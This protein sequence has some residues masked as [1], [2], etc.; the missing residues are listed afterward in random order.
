MTE[1]EE[2]MLVLEINREV[3]HHRML[4]QQFVKSQNKLERLYRKLDAKPSSQRS[5]P[6]KLPTS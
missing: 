6:N 4:A 3:K 5:L 2:C 1:F